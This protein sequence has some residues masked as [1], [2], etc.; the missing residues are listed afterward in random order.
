MEN[1]RRILLIPFLFA[2]AMAGGAAGADEED[3]FWAPTPPRLSYIDGQVSYWRQGA[4]EWAGARPNLA[5]AEG[6]AL[7]A[8]KGSNFEVQF[9][10]R[11]FVRADED[12][13]LTLMNQEADFIQFKVTSGLVSFDI[14]NMKVGDRVEVDT[15]D[16]L[17]VI[18]QPGYYRVEVNANTHFITRRG[19]RAMVTTADGRTLSI[20]P[21]EDI[22]IT[23]GDPVQVATYAAPAPDA[24]DRWN[25]ARS[26]RTGESV[27]SRYLPP[28]VYG[29]EE[30]DDHQRG[31]HPL[32]QHELAP[33]RPH[34]A[35]RQ[36][37]PGAH[38]GDGGDTLPPRGFRAGSGRDAHQAH[39]PQP[40]RRRAER[41]PAPAGHRHPAGGLHPAAARESPALEG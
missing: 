3:D 26:E 25:D 28:D 31:R 5:L 10:N 15:P 37:R 34:G 19:G 23:A 8:G 17:F 16:A 24:W 7:Y 36:I 13:Q 12:S 41:G 2:L 9:D 29:A 32:P 4:D 38:P 21:S 22:V 35:R 33:S 30:L 39:P 11:S 1:L 14:R 20:Y 18:E 40:D 27:S 6:D